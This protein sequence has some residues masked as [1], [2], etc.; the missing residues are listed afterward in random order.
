MARLRRLINGRFMRLKSGRL[1][2]HIALLFR[3]QSHR[4]REREVSLDESQKLSHNGNLKT[5]RR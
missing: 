2:R 1:M 5:S 3:S 4:H